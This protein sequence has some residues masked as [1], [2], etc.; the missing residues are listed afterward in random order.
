M[1]LE[2][3]YTVNCNNGRPRQSCYSKESAKITEKVKD[4]VRFPLINK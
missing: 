1:N 2:A 3:R 4:V